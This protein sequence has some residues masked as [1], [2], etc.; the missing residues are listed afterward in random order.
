MNKNDSNIYERVSG[1]VQSENS[2]GVNGCEL[3]AIKVMEITWSGREYL[4]KSADFPSRK[5]WPKLVQ[6]RNSLKR[7]TSTIDKSVVV[8]CGGPKS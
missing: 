4:R 8:S 7:E 6:P 3:W 1:T 2:L 5:K